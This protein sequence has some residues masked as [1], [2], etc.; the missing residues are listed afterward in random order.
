MSTAT[1]APE[2]I[3]PIRLALRAAQVPPSA[4]AALDA[5]AKALIAQGVDVINLTSGEPAFPTVEPAAQAALD[6]IATDFTRY[7]PAAGIPELRAATA[8]FINRH[9]T[10]YEPGQV[11]ITAGAKQALHYA[12]TTLVEPGDEI[13]I[14]APYWVSYPHLAALAGGTLVPVQP[15]PGAGLK[16]TADQLRAAVTDRTRVL[17]LNN[18]SNPSGVVYDRTELAALVQVA[19]D[20][21]L[22]IISDEICDHWVF[23]DSEHTSVAALS[24]EADQRTLTIGGVSKTFAMTGWR[25]GWVAAPTPVAAAITA[26]QSHTASAPSSISQ[27]AALGALT[28]DLAPELERRRRELDD[29]R[30]TTLKALAAIQGIEVDGD[31]TGAFFLLADV[32]GTYGHTLADR[33][34]ISAA[35]FAKL[36][37]TEAN[38]AVVPGADFAAPNHVRI[39]YTVPPD[40]LAEALDRIADFIERLGR[41]SG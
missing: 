3:S 15:A 41:A 29:R 6:A 39:S 1:P 38:V 30:L 24:P 32:S 10:A 25:I 18:P 36:L 13:L 4:T 2:A 8:D 11:V 26:I 35:D 14:P 28:A 16:V 20:H 7:T 22:A 5:Q 9:G 12:F 40:R 33:T 27:K 34:V 19:I 21:D 31:P 23:G 17:L 37:L